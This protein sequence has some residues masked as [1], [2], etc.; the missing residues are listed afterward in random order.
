MLLKGY[1]ASSIVF[2]IRRRRRRGRGEEE[3]EESSLTLSITS[4]TTSFAS[5]FDLPRRRAKKF[6]VNI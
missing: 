3:E 6:I 2:H 5:G 4:T 1:A